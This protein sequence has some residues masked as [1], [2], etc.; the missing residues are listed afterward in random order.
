MI[1]LGTAFKAF[2]GTLFSDE[3]AA[4]V[5]SALAGKTLLA[6]ETPA[7]PAA[8][9]VKAPAPV[10]VPPPTQ[11]PAVTLLAMLQREARFVDFLQEELTGFSDA[12]VGAVAKDIHR[13]CRKVVGRVF[14]LERVEASEEGSRVTVEPA[15]SSQWKVTGKVDGGPPFTGQ[16]VHGGWRATKCELPQFAGKADVALIVAPAELE[17]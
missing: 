12:E 9:P 13:D 7:Q 3:K 11:N 17:V 16:V 14:G 4:L 2:F 15:A 10:V 6:P 5:E 8:A 1:H